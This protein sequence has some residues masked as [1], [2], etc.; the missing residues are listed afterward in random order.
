MVIRPGG[1]RVR[2]QY[3]LQGLV[4]RTWGDAEYPEAREYDEYG[5]LVGMTTYRGGSGWS[6][7]S[8]PADPGPGDRTSWDFDEA[9]GLL[10]S[11]TDAA[12]AA[13]EYAY[14]AGARRRTRTWARRTPD[15]DRVVTTYGYDAAT[16]ELTTVEYSDGTPEVSY[17]Y[18]R[19]GRARAVT[20][21]A[22]ARSFSYG[23]IDL[24]LQR[25]E[26]AGLIPST[27]VRSYEQAAGG[28]AGRANGFSL[29]PGYSLSYL[30]DANGR[31][32]D[33]RWQVDGSA[34]TLHYGRQNGSDLVF[35]RSYE[36]GVSTSLAYEPARDLPVAVTNGTV[37]R[38][39]Q[40]FD[41]R[42]R[43]SIVQMDGGAFSGPAFTRYAY[44]AKS[45]LTGA[46]SYLGADVDDTSSEI[47]ARR[48]TYGYDSSGN[49][50]SAEYGI[51]TSLAYVSNELNQY[52]R[53]DGDASGAVRF[54]YDADG[55]VAAEER[56]GKRRRYRW[57][58]E[59]R[60]I[61]VEPETP[62][63]GDVRSEYLYDHLGRRVRKLVETRLADGTWAAPVAR[64]FVYDGW[65]VVSE[66][67]CAGHVTGRYV[68]GLDLSGSL[69][70]AGGVGGLAATIAGGSAL[71]YLY[72]ANGNVT[73]AVGAGSA[74]GQEASY[75]YD[76][77]ANLLS[78]AGP[79]AGANPFR[80]STKYY[81][82]ETG[83]YYYGYRYY[84]PELGRWL[85]R[86]P[87]EEDGG[88]NLYR[89][90][91][92]EPVGRTDYLGLW[93]K[94]VHYGNTKRW[95]RNLGFSERAA[96]AI[97]PAEEGLDYGATSFMP[98]IGDHRYHFNRNRNSTDSR[99]AL[100]RAHI[101]E[102]K[103]SCLDSS[104]SGSRPEEACQKLGTGLHPLQDWVAHGDYGAFDD[105]EVYTVHNQYSPQRING[106]GRRHRLSR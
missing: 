56:S 74:P 16:G 96:E 88:A 8:W 89:L 7:D 53:V 54:E 47:P 6:A 13:V 15:G 99:L 41:A 58:A 85:S 3:D 94:N 82:D 27:V 1:T 30:F 95:S 31:V 79:Q 45:Q 81:D 69:Q 39:R 86:D 26:A 105:G 48:R 57:D 37:S 98:I 19:L 62:M 91:G 67:D 68:W 78:A 21:A 22:G 75:E 97:G 20:D 60:L 80:F 77:Y 90:L 34:G 44:D 72:D 52:Q 103:L 29:E 83:L 93:S 100:F 18:D 46:S 70:G 63:A 10:L 92:N 65:Q 36:A 25:E 55:N 66:A 64:C 11:K 42:G 102:A 2:R 49:R 35:G 40:A 9:T 104:G 43:T 38:F 73:Q 23:A 50:L 28:L 61:A 33:V 17:S 87:I 76:P 5:Q 12:G 101:R 106:A 71:H 24:Q 14:V 4:V 84:S 51:A 32:S 59:N